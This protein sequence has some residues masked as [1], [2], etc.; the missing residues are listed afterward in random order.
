MEIGENGAHPV[1]LAHNT[2]SAMKRHAVNGY[3][4][5]C[6]YLRIQNA[7]LLIAWSYLPVANLLS[8][9]R[10]FRRQNIRY[11]AE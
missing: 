11:K 10:D 1:G 6:R 8:E 7:V 5:Q 3:R 9:H 4:I 2:F